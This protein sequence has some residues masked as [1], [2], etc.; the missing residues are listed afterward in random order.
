MDDTNIDRREFLKKSA[1]API[2]ATGLLAQEGG[3]LA[4]NGEQSA[5]DEPSAVRTTR[6]IALDYPEQLEGGPRQ[7][8]LL[9]TDRLDDEPDVSEVDGCA[10]SD[11]PP[12]ELGVWEGIIVDWKNEAGDFGFGFYGGTPTIRAD[13]LVELDTIV[14]DEQDTPV[15]LGTP[16]IVNRTLECP[17]EWVGMN[18]TQL[19]GI[20]IK[21][22]EGVST[23]G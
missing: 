7:K 20:D 10:F 13:E 21:T 17:G 15:P 12:E 6:R 8:V 9:M 5:Q 1:V 22:G 14:V 2:G 19:P 18:A 23:D 16:F 11:W 3:L 4:Q